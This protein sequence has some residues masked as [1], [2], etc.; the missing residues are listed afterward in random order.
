MSRLSVVVSLL[1]LAT[2]CSGTSKESDTESTTESEGTCEET[3]GTV[4][5]VVYNEGGTEVWPDAEVGI[6]Q[7]G[8][9]VDT[10]T[11][12][13]D[14]AYSIE[15]EAG[16]YTLYFSWSDEVYDTGVGYTECYTSEYTVTVEA[17]GEHTQDLVVEECISADKPNLYLY[18]D[19]DTLM[20]VELEL[21]LGQ[22][23]LAS[24]PRYRD[25]WT[26]IAH[27][28]GFFSVRDQRAPFLFYEV[29][30]NKHQPAWLQ[31]DVGWCLPADGAVEAM[32]ELLRAYDFTE[33][34]VADFVEAWEIDLPKTES[35]AVYPQRDVEDF[36][37]VHVSPSLPLDRLWL[38]VTDG[39]GCALPEPVIE[40]LDRRGAHAVEWGVVLDDIAR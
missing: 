29:S 27:P 38:L 10:A 5:G 11:A 37:R 25:G 32:G 34:E 16:T 7:S 31:R 22:S 1:A 26:G 39:A 36:A 23:V 6:Y 14:G 9:Q 40:P 24:A 18:P 28:D 4:S 19:R 20:H 2:A 30:L 12:D 15:L 33:R 17:C 8:S 21:D 3:T 35:Y 13:G